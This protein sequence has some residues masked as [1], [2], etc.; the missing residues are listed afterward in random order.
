GKLLTGEKFKDIAALK[1][2]LAENR[3]PDLYRCLSEKLLTFA[4]GRGVEYYDAPTIDLLVAHLEK[5]NGKLSEL[6]HAITESAPF[7]KRRGGH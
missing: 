7:Q 6:V 3:K 5:N 4:V 2:S 1:T